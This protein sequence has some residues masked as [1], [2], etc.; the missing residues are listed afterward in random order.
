M[1]V[2]AL[3]LFCYNTVMVW[4]LASVL[5][6]YLIWGGRRGCALGLG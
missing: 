2:L 3:F 5:T 1:T 4:A 6:P